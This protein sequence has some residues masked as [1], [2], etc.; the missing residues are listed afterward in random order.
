MFKMR[1]VKNVFELSINLMSE[2]SRNILFFWKSPSLLKQAEL[3]S[4]LRIGSTSS[5]HIVH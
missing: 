3:D 5:I 2:Y 1:L 4:A